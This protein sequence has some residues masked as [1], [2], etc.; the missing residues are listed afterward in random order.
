MKHHR[1][2]IV[3][4]EISK[5]DLSKAANENRLFA[6]DL[7]VGLSSHPKQLPSKQFYDETGDRIFQSIMHMQE[8]YLTRSEYDILDQ[9]RQ[10]FLH[11]FS[12]RGGSFK[13]NELRYH[14]NSKICR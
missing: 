1:Y 3:P 5:P 2:S 12:N 9:Y 8:Y 10:D 11:L 4:S 6:H 13:L 14:H 7:Q